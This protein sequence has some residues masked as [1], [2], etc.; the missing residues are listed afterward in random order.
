MG[1]VQSLIVS[2]ASVGQH[3]QASERMSVPCL[4]RKNGITDT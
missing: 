2:S 1:Y 4:S 3:G